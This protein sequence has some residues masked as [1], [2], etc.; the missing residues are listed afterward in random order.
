[1]KNGMGCYDDTLSSSK[2]LPI[3]VFV[4]FHYV[5]I[6]YFYDKFRCLYDWLVNFFLSCNVYSSDNNFK[7]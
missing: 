7:T 3:P 1:M 5:N 4:G 2:L 6:L